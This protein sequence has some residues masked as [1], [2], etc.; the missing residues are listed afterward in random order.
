M[1]KEKGAGMGKAGTGVGWAGKP[2]CRARQKRRTVLKVIVGSALIAGLSSQWGLSVSLEKFNRAVPVSMTPL[3]RL[4]A[5][6]PGARYQGV[7]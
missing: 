1:T 3:P 4:V 6:P 2:P 7:P 5:S